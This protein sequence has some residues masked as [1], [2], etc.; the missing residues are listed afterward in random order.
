MSFLLR[1]AEFLRDE[2]LEICLIAHEDVF[3]RDLFR[4]LSVSFIVVASSMIEL[5]VSGDVQGPI[6]VEVA[7]YFPSLVRIQALLV[8]TRGE[9]ILLEVADKATLQLLVLHWILE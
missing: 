3:K 2:L 7:D 9:A 4:I 5:N 6:A 8:A 1:S